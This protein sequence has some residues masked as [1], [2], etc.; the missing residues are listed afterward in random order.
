MGTVH[1]EKEESNTAIYWCGMTAAEKH[2]CVSRKMPGDR[3]CI[4][5]LS[6]RKKAHTR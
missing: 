3:F 5:C 2:R 6:N 1:I 4:R